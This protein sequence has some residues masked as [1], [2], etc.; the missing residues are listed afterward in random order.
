MQYKWDRDKALIK[1]QQAKK[2]AQ[3]SN[4]KRKELVKKLQDNDKLLRE[5]DANIMGIREYI[6]MV[7]Q[8]NQQYQGQG[9]EEEMEMPPQGGEEEMI[10]GEG[11]GEGEGEGEQGDVPVE[12][13]SLS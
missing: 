4:Q 9:D 7:K 10:E 6:E 5:Y 3:A 1:K 8:K 2:L 11:H 13:G 12:Q